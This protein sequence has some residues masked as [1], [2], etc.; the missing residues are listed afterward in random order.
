VILTDSFGMSSE[1][2][3]KIIITKPPDYDE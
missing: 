2:S 3:F 1:Y